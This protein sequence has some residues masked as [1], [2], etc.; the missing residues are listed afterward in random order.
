M[1]RSSDKATETS[2]LVH[3]YS[4]NYLTP[5]FW[6]GLA[7]FYSWKDLQVYEIHKW[8]KAYYIE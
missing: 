3:L 2:Y 1:D 4:F 7:L 8:I 5:L 6:L